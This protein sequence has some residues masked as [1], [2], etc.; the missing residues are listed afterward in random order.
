M[1]RII[2]ALACAL[3]LLAVVSGCNKPSDSEE[4]VYTVTAYPITA[5]AIDTGSPTEFTVTDCGTYAS[6][7]HRDVVC[8]VASNTAFSK[9]ITD[10]ADIRYYTHIFTAG[11]TVYCY[12]RLSGE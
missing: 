4:G 3:G 5:Q 9:T 2:T 6:V 10:P 11:G 1:K 12:R 7:L 8:Y